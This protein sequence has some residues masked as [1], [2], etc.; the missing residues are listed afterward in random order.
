[1]KLPHDHKRAPA[2]TILCIE[3]CPEIL[4]LLQKTLQVCDYRVLPASSGSEGLELFAL[5]ES[6]IDAIVLDLHLPDMTGKDVAVAIKKKHPHLPII[7]F[8]GCLRDL[9]L[10]LTECFDEFIEKP[11][12]EEIPR[13]L[14]RLLNKTVTC[15]RGQT[16]NQSATR[17]LLELH[18]RDIS[19]RLLGDERYATSVEFVSQRGPYA[20]PLS[21]FLDLWND[22]VQT[23]LRAGLI[24]EMHLER[25][26]NGLSRIAG[27]RRET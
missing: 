7:L 4:D 8:S 20:L 16:P 26:R 24:T 9:Y 12:L 17:I 6:S 22:V 2:A 5:N 21:D 11:M 27:N 3:D 1:M 13:T 23:A 14:K 15:G 25:N 19:V 18:R 10:E